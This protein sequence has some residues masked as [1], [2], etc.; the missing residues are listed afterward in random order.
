[1]WTQKLK[2]DVDMSVR[3]LSAICENGEQNRLDNSPGQALVVSIW[4]SGFTRVESSADGPW[5]GAGI[6]LTLEQ[7]SQLRLGTIKT[8]GAILSEYSP[9]QSF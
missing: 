7:Q 3:I 6:C 4:M 2:I 5:Q 1:M 8:I 9:H